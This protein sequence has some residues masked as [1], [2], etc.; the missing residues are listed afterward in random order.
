MSSIEAFIAANRFGL[1]AKNDELSTISADP[2]GWLH[3]QL[4][5]RHA[6]VAAYDGLPSTLQALE[7]LKGYREDKKMF[8]K[9]RA[10]GGGE[11]TAD[12]AKLKSMLK[13]QG[14]DYMTDVARRT[15]V[16]AQSDA[17]FFER[18]VQFWSNH[19]T[20]SSTK[21]F[22]MGLLAD[23]E[24]EAIRP[25]IMGDFLTLLRASTRHP[26]MLM[27]LDNQRSIG[28]NSPGGKFGQ[29]GLN[30]NLAREIMELHTLGVNGGYTQNDVTEFAKILTGWS[31]DMDQ[32]GDGSGFF[33]RPMVH[34][35]GPK[36]LL[37][38]VYEQDGVNEGEKALATFAYHPSTAK[39]IATKLARHFI[40]DDPPASAVNQLAVAFTRSNGKLLPV[41]KTLLSL[42]ET[43]AEPLAKVKTP[44]DYVLSMLRASGTGGEVEDIKLVGAFKL[45]G[46]VPFSAPSPAGWSDQA[47]DWVGAEALLQRIDLARK[48]ARGIYTKISPDD[49]LEQTI[50][51]VASGETRFAVSRAGS[52]EEA[53][54]ILFASPEFQRR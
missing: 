46:Q 22:Q 15:R 50:G 12:A 24:R 20:V 6:K 27:Y 52:K 3:A 14:K 7:E 4:N 35:P 11:V 33:F 39:F 8:K 34:E 48:I 32:R 42:P 2:T 25:H 36:N 51:P 29:K 49:L 31:I 41:Y 17:P 30:E 40:A 44:N 53:I 5:A 13:A 1:G 26:A 45:L 10:A 16:I 28:P 21:P 47:K 23:F 19:F 43:W 37:G 9:A 54:T 38:E 18:L